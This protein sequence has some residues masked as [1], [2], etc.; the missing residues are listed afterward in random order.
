[1][2][3]ALFVRPVFRIFAECR[4]VY[5]VASLSFT[6]AH[7]F[8]RAEALDG[9]Q[10]K[11]HIWGCRSRALLPD[12]TPLTRITRCCQH[13][14]LFIPSL[15]VY[16]RSCGRAVCVPDFPSAL[17]SCLASLGGQVVPSFAL[18][19]SIIA[20]GSVTDGAD[21]VGPGK[22][23]VADAAIQL[24][25]IPACCCALRCVV[26]L[27][28][29]RGLCLQPLACCSV[30]SRNHAAQF[31]HA[32]LMRQLL[33]PSAQ[34]TASISLLRI[35][36]GRLARQAGRPRIY[37]MGAAGQGI[38]GRLRSH[39]RLSDAAPTQGA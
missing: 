6:N 37:K 17:Y 32:A 10:G 33:D 4:G 26:V 34:E 35:K 31:P 5:F 19:W 39:K 27:L 12:L 30:R 23:S 29:L 13:S 28:L 24:Q 25:G 15:N 20:R 18:R 9:G 36:C 7:V 22:S 14:Y 11:R 2:C 1:M 21:G 3:H 38:G 8:L 16:R